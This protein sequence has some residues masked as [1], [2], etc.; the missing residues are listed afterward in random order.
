MA[1]GGPVR[2]DG[3]QHFSGRELSGNDDDNGDR[4]LGEHLRILGSLTPKKCE[5]FGESATAF[6][7]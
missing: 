5:F 6:D 7:G 2:V 4:C 1:D 3:D